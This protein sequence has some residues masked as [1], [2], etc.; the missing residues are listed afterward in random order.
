MQHLLVFQNVVRKTVARHNPALAN[1]LIEAA[2]QIIVAE[3]AALPLKP[4]PP[5]HVRLKLDRHGGKSHLRFTGR[6]ANFYVIQASTDLVNWQ[7]V[8]AT[9][10]ED[11][12]PFE[13]ED[14]ES[15]KRPFRFYRLAQP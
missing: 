11:S 8:G 6:N 7:V 1:D 9:L 10:T 2:N 4:L 14:Q 5:G 15:A 3:L 12:A 13:F